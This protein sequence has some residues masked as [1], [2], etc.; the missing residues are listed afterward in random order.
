M[1]I[2]QCSKKIVEARTRAIL[3][4]FLNLFL[5]IGKGGAGVLSGSGR[6]SLRENLQK[7]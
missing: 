7:R 4:I 5:A 3:F 2:K 6:I 1:V